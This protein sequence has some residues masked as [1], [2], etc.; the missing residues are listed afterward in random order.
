MKKNSEIF[1]ETYGYIR[2]TYKAKRGSFYVD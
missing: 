1:P 2:K